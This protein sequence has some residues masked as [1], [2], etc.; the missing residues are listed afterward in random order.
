M[1]HTAWARRTKSRGPK[2]L[3]LEVGAWRAPRLL[4]CNNFISYLRS[5]HFKR[6]PWFVSIHICNYFISKVCK[7]SYIFI[8][9][10]VLPHICNHNI[11]PEKYCWARSILKEL[12]RNSLVPHYGH[13]SWNWPWLLL[14]G[15][16]LFSCFL[17]SPTTSFFLLR[18][19]HWL[20]LLYYLIDELEHQPQINVPVPPHNSFGNQK[21]K[22]ESHT[23]NWSSTKERHSF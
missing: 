20:V 3:Q 12:K 5:F 11:L 19:L 15:I 16:F 10:S 4:V 17:P 6:M 8:G 22:L 9:S 18:W 1:C 13:V 2:G 21:P 23:F 7:A 14:K